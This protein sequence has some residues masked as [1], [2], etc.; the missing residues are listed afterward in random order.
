MDKRLTVARR[1]LASLRSEKTIVLAILIQLLI[2]AF[3]SFLA[4]GLVSM[5]DPGS[6]SNGFVVSFGVTGDASADLAPVLASDDSWEA[7]HY[8]TQRAAMRDFRSGRIHAVLAVDRTADGSVRV[9]AIAPDGNIKTTLVV[10]QIKE[11]LDKLERRERA[12]FASRLERSPV[13]PP[14]ETGASPYFGFTYTVLIPLLMFLPVFIS[15]SVAVDTIAEEYDRGTLELL[16]VTPLTGVDIVD[17]KLL[18]MGILA[19]VQA[20]AW[21]V[22]LSFNGTNVANPLEIVALVAA[23]SVAIVAIGAILA[24]RFRDRKQAQ[25][26]FSMAM[27]VV[28]SG[29]Y[30]LPEAPA[31]TVARLAIGSPT[32]FTHAMVALYLACS[33]AGYALVRRVVGVRGLLTTA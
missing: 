33:L 11:V 23:F 22:L 15:G 4:V 16:R 28:F 2:A 14:P 26:L 17:G 8:R 27:L 18:A 5:Y 30:L 13:A 21:L 6:A 25:F 9:T 10:T 20:A 12:R 24:L 29:T 19:P 31:N 7:E 32:P 1:E 3:S